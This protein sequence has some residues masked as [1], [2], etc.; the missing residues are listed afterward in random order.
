IKT[1]SGSSN[2]KDHQIVPHDEWIKERIAFLAR[3]KEFSR[4]RDELNRQRRELPW[5]RVDKQY[6]FEGPSG[7]ESLADLFQN[8]SQL[9]V[10]HFM[11]E[12]ELD[13]GCVH[14]SFW[15]DHFDGADI[16]LN[17]R[18]TTFVVISHAPLSKIEAFKKR[19]GWRFK[20]LSAFNTDFNY[21]YQVSFK[22]ENAQKATAK[23]NYTQPAGDDMERECASAFYKD[24]SGAV[25]HTY[26]C[27]ARGIDLLNGTYNFL[28]LT[29]KG[30]DENVPEGPPAWVRYHDQYDR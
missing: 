28:D 25:F 6:I 18:D 21:D 11:F 13:E 14:C 22:P 17:H 23:Y 7:K 27:Y 26:S 29:A 9:L 20:W 16:H 1:D 2:I 30:R 12:P 5:E 10:Y 15:A 19:M 3:E 4:L 8:R 24:P